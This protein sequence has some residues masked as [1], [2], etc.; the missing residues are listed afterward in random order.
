MEI[1]N[2]EMERREYFFLTP[3]EN[4]EMALCD[5]K[6]FQSLIDRKHEEH[7]NRMQSRQ[8]A[9]EDPYGLDFGGSVTGKP[10]IVGSKKLTK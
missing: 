6:C 4:E 10:F 3:R 8:R 5:T 9:G 7:T 2:S 1:Y